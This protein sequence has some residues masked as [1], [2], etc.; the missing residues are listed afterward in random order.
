MDV[1]LPL[2]RKRLRV[3]LA[4]RRRRSERVGVI[5]LLTRPLGLPA[6]VGEGVGAALVR[7]TL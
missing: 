1:A 4:E 6:A 7:T 2:E 5:S 3:D